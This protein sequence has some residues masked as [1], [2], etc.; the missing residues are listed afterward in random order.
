MIRPGTLAGC[1]RQVIIR[2]VLT[3]LAR[4]TLPDNRT[5]GFGGRLYSFRVGSVLFVCVGADDV[6]YHDAAN[7]ACSG[8][9]LA[10]YSCYVGIDIASGVG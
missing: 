2:H 1:G 9:R 6:V 10:G 3:Y 5:P 4:Y 8:T 7:W